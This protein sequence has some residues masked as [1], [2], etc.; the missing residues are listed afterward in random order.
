M[1]N[2]IISLE[3]HI[4]HELFSNN[5][6]KSFNYGTLLFI[7][8]FGI[9]IYFIKQANKPAWLRIYVVLLCLFLCFGYMTG[10]DWRVYED[11]YTHINF[12]NLFTTIFK[13]PDIISTCFL[14]GS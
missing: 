11:I 14:L 3:N 13:N 5:I 7:I 8:L 1:E 12:N 4:H 9:R 10:T 2:K 6:T